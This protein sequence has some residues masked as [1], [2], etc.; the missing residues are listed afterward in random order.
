[1]ITS[2]GGM[3]SGGCKVVI[4]LS[5]VDQ[6]IDSNRPGWSQ[7]GVVASGSFQPLE[8]TSLLSNQDTGVEGGLLSVNG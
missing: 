7:G 4:T 2:K 6:P 1:M 5:Q 8:G 3:I